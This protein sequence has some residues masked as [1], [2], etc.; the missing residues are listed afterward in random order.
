LAAIELTHLKR[1]A[2]VTSPLSDQPAPQTA[3]KT[4]TTLRVKGSRIEGA[5]CDRLTI[6]RS[7]S[8][9]A[10]GWRRR[11]LVGNSA[12]VFELSF[13]V[14]CRS[15]VRSF[16]FFFASSL[17]SSPP[18]PLSAVS[19]LSLSPPL[20]LPLRPP[21]SPFAPPLLHLFP[22]SSLHPQML[23]LLKSGNLAQI[24]PRAT[25]AR[26]LHHRSLRHSHYVLLRHVG[27]LLADL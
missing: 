10:G 3:P 8:R 21:P 17:S 14:R 26:R 16:Y 9:S 2:S 27:D 20:L 7:F 11:S 19:S 18:S 5:L 15:L 13:S 23:N 22:P 12:S 4:A 6:R 1:T 25:N 24:P